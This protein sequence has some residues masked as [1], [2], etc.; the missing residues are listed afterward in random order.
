MKFFDWGVEFLNQK[1]ETLDI[2]STKKDVQFQS[3]KLVFCN[4]KKYPSIF[5]ATKE[6]DSEGIYHK[7]FDEE[8][9]W[10][11]VDHFRIFEISS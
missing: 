3:G 5:H 8:E 1:P 7:V 4:G 2:T 9:F 10:E 11:D 6:I